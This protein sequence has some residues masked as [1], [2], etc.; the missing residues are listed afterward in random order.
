MAITM[1]IFA[2]VGVATPNEYYLVKG[3]P[4]VTKT[5][6]I[7]IA[8]TFLLFF[9]I[10]FYKPTWGAT[11]WIWTAEIFSMNVRAQAV[12]MCSQ[13]QNVANSILQQFFPT[14]LANCGFYTFYFF[15]GINVLLALF[16][17]FLVPETRKVSLEEMDVLFG[18]ANHVE[19]GGDLL[20]VEDTHHA[21][22][23]VDNVINHTDNNTTEMHQPV[24]R[25]GYTTELKE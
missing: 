24:G 1:L 12:G 16:V 17:W 4:T 7:G 2:T 23:G 8:L 14:F 15:A 9:F 11:V 6:P 20:H 10:L 3:V 18:G 13:M 21:H 22:V 19:K 25:E 5:Q